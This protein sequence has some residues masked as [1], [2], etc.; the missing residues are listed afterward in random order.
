MIS[1]SFHSNFEGDLEFNIV[2]HK[3]EVIKHSIPSISFGY[4]SLIPFNPTESRRSGQRWAGDEGEKGDE[5]GRRTKWTAA[6]LR[7]RRARFR[8]K[9]ATVRNT[10]L[11]FSALLRV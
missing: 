10:P 3:F 5:K 6:D 7:M 9:S 4:L 11:F 1:Y 8:R 2:R